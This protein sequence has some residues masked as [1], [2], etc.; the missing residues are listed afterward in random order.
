MTWSLALSPAALEDLVTATDWYD[1][2]QPGLGDVFV[3]S[4]GDC[5]SRIARMPHAF[6]ESALG[7]RSALLRRFPYAVLFRVRD[8]RIEVLAVW[9]GHRDSRDWLDRL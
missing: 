3:R 8:E 7:V 4:V 5:F 9:H 1:S 6:P 2:R